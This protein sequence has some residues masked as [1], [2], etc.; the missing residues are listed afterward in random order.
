MACLR[1][2]KLDFFTIKTQLLSYFSLVAI[3]LMLGFMGS[4]VA[5]LCITGAWFIALQASNIFAIQEKN[6]LECLYGSV[7]VALKDIVLGR[8]IFMLLNYFISF[9]VVVA[10]YIGFALY[11]NNAINLTDIMLGFGLSFFIFSAITGIQMPLFFKMG[12]TKAKIMALVPFLIIMLLVVIPS[13]INILSDLVQSAMA[14]Q[15]MIIA[16]GI[17]ASC[18]IQFVSYKVAVIAYRKRK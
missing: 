14:N 6:N 4:P 5:V 15:G 10:L 2:T 7:S 8:Y 11:G 3:I 13:F 1:I 17:I 9:L 12:Y 18:I 16:V